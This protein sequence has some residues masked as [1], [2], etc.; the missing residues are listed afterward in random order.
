[1][2]RKVLLA[3]A[4][5]M[6]VNLVIQAQDAIY[7][8]PKE[9]HASDARIVQEMYVTYHTHDSIVSDPVTGA[10][11]VIQVQDS[12]SVEPID[13]ASSGGPAR[14]ATDDFNYTDKDGIQIKCYV[15]YYPSVDAAGKPITLSALLVRPR[16]IAFQ[17]LNDVIVGCHITITSNKECPSSYYSTNPLDV[18]VGAF[19]GGPE[20]SDVG[21]MT[22]Y[23]TRSVNNPANNN[24]LVIMPDYEGYGVTRDRAHPYLYQ[25]LTAR[26]VVDAA[27]Y[28]L[29]L[30][31]ALSAENDGDPLRDNWR[32]LTVG[33]SQGGSVSLATH[34]FIEQNG[35]AEELHFAGSVCGDGP[36][37]PLSTLDYYMHDSGQVLNRDGEVQ[38]D[39][40]TSHIME[41]LTMPVVMPLIL[42]G[43]IDSNPYMK[44][45]KLSDYLSPMFLHTGVIEMIEGKANNS[46]CKTT[47]DITKA[48]YQMCENGITYTDPVTGVTYEHSAES[49]CQMF[50]IHSSTLSLGIMGFEVIADLEYVLTPECLEY[51]RS[52]DLND[53]PSGH[54]DPMIDLHRAIASN[55]MGHGWKPQHRIG[56]FHSPFDMVVPYVNYLSVRNEFQAAGADMSLFYLIDDSSDDH[57]AAGKQFF[58]TQKYDVQL[59][60]WVLYGEN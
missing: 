17:P 44:Q 27:R 24:N 11:Q 1:M 49:V 32:M 59:I 40:H 51:F 4:M 10:T 16:S 23:A 57:V 50:P 18:A 25:E 22:Y 39:K 21:M 12:I 33:Y 56:F 37:N 58:F 6:M 42:K 43:M 52:H 26:Q 41:W 47:D 8:I 14:A 7:D 5:L 60:K 55:N 45:H 20:T 19:V 53:V 13:M 15:F 29:A 34:R 54:G 38:S 46:T 48:F 30:Y 28:G 36:Y 2:N 31:Q 9:V 3:L 35:L